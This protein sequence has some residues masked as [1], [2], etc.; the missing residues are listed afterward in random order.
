[1][2]AN[3]CA[4]LHFPPGVDVSQAYDTGAHWKMI[5]NIAIKFMTMNIAE[6]TYKL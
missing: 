4:G 2:S 6:T 5:Y 3:V 1:M